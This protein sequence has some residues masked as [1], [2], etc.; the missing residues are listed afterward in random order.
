MAN[1]MLKVG[2][3]VEGEGEVKAAPLLIRRLAQSRNP[4]QEL[5]TEVRRIPKSKLLRPCEFENAIEVLSRQIG[6]S[7][8]I[9]V[10]LDADDDCPVDLALGLLSRARTAHGDI[11][12]SLVVANREYEGWFLAA[13]SS[14]AR[15]GHIRSP[16]KIVVNCESVRGAKEWITTQRSQGDPYVP[17]RHQAIFSA[18]I[19]LNEARGAPSF[20]KLEKEVALMIDAH[21]NNHS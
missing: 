9:L 12:V 21:V 17:T 11:K 3:I 20:R 19:D 13:A 18:V 6:R 5:S 2:I 14:L 7:N 8:P 4:A 15:K 10:V 16:F 1:V